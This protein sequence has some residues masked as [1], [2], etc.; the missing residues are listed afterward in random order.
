MPAIN[1]GWKGLYMQNKDCGFTLVELA[2]VMIIIG[3]L[4]GG[5]LKGQQLIEN[6]K[7]TAVISKVKAYT[8][9]YYSFT[10]AY[11]G[12]AGDLRNA[13][14]RLSGCSAGNGNFCA[15]GNGDAIV[16]SPFNLGLGGDALVQENIM[17]WKHLALADLISGVDPT[18]PIDPSDDEFAYGS[19]LPSSVFGGG[20]QLIYGNDYIDGMYGHMLRLTRNLEGAID[21][22]VQGNQLLT[23]AQAA[24]IDRKIDDGRPNSGNVDG[25]YALCDPG[26]VYD[27]Q[28]KSKN[29]WMLFVID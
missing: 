2:I 8:S 13:Q 11:G 4:I 22:T 10:D 24:A 18:A 16:G 9:A 15:A 29:C 6:A 3:L 7:I 25:E 26:G 21:S 1:S 14:T 12:I 5:V 27:E 20:W 28:N 23:S 17:F 19:S